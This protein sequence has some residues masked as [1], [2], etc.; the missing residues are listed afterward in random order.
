MATAVPAAISHGVSRGCA[1]RAFA[2][3]RVSN[4]PQSKPPPIAHVLI[5]SLPRRSASPRGEVERE[6]WRQPQPIDRS[7]R[8]NAEKERDLCE[9]KPAVVGP[10]QGGD[11]AG[12]E[13]PVDAAGGDE[14]ADADQP[15]VEKRNVA[16]RASAS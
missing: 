2:P 14:H 5:A 8:G 15:S 16:S 3:M 6:P 11:A 12:Q 9:Q 1:R 13:P 4:A 10:D 7:N